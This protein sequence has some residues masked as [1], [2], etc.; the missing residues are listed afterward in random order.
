MTRPLTILIAVLFGALALGLGGCS[1]VGVKPNPDVNYTLVAPAAA[2]AATETVKQRIAL[3]AV[4]AAKLQTTNWVDGQGCSHRCNLSKGTCSVYCPNESYP[5][6][7]LVL[8]NGGWMF[9]LPMTNMGMWARAATNGIQVKT[10]GEG[11]AT[12]P[13]KTNRKDVFKLSVLGETN[14]SYVNK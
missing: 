6:H 7:G 11:W 14:F 5:I 4:T 8:D 13:L 2:V 12:L 10:N 1:T 9:V 3:P